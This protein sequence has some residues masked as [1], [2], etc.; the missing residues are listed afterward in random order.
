MRIYI[1]DKENGEFIREADAYLNLQESRI[2]EKF[3]YIIPQNATEIKPPVAG[4]NEK[5]IFKNNKWSIV[6]DFRNQKFF[7]TK[8]NRT[9]I[10]D[11]LGEPP[12]DCIAFNTK[13]FNEYIKSLDYN[14]IRNNLK[15]LIE[16]LYQIKLDENILVGRHYLTLKQ[17]EYFQQ[18]IIEIN[19][20]RTKIQEQINEINKRLKNKIST[21][22]KNLLTEQQLSLYKQMDNI[23]I[24]L[25]V[26]NK[27]RK[28]V[29]IPCTYEEFIEINSILRTFYLELNKDKKYEI[30][31]LALTKN[32]DLIM[33]EQRLRRK[34]I[35]F[36]AKTGNEKIS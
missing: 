11:K 36:Y 2:Q 32:E 14:V 5:Q 18:L 30:S 4:K 8:K 31:R 13:E 6:K 16:E 15:A 1:Y 21:K 7:D 34:G 22:D 27:R 9:I 10:M 20:D 24:E 25:T 3:I 23:K 19:N 28:E 35:N 29:V 12:E 26:K 17:Y 33:F